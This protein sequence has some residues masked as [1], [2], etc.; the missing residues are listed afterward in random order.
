MRS[1]E[2]DWM[3]REQIVATTY[4]VGAALNDLKFQAR[5]IDAMTHATVSSHLASAVRMLAEV[6]TLS[7]LP[8][9]ERRRRLRMLR[10]ALAVANTSN[11]V[12]EDELKWKTATG[13]RVSRMLLWH[14]ASALTR[15]IGHG[16]ARL[17]GRS[18]N[19]IADPGIAGVET[20]VS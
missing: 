4:E 13:I 1:Y 15:E 7:A 19:G 3:S 18:C 10:D 8:E 12:G 6:Q 5:L 2:T 14:L 11:L 17:R 20:R 9:P 16:L